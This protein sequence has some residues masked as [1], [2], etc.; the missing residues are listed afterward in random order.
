LLQHQGVNLNLLQDKYT[1]PRGFW[2]SNHKVKHLDRPVYLRL[3]RVEA[4]AESHFRLKLL[5]WI[6]VGLERRV[7]MGGHSLGAS[8][9]DAVATLT[10][11]TG[12]DVLDCGS[13]ADDDDDL[14]FLP[15]GW[16]DHQILGISDI[17]GPFVYDGKTGLYLLNNRYIRKEHKP[18]E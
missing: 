7:V 13:D 12:L 4:E 10:R 6:T 14:C 2:L 5:L 1:E 18:R 3:R 11:I 8:S 16:G 15:F 9:G 17:H